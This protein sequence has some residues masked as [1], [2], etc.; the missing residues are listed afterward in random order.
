[1]MK[2]L[3]A[4]FVIF[5][6]IV[7][8]AGCDASKRAGG[9]ASAAIDT[10]TAN[11]GIDTVT[12]SK[13]S[14]VKIEPRGT[15]DF[16]KQAHRGGRGLMPENTIRAMINAINLDV[17]TLEM[18]AVITSDRKVILSHD[19]YFNSETT[20]PEDGS[21]I[22]KQ[23][24]DSFSIYKMTYEKTKTFDVGLK[25]YPAFPKQ[26]KVKA[27][28]PLLSDVI[29]SVEAYTAAKN[30]KPV[31]YNIE[32]KSRPSGDNKLHPAPEEYVELIMGVINQK[33]IRPRTIIQ[34][35]DFRTLQVMHKKYADVALAA[36][37]ENTRSLDDNI[38]D[39]GFTPTIYSP[40]FRLVTKELVEQ[41]HRLNM[42]IIPW[43]V[44]DK[45]KINSLKEWGVDGIISD[46]PDL[47][48]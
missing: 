35:F 25:P 45:E 2:N 1:M 13:S 30:K 22:T 6:V 10:V 21:I 41:C 28:K 44:N 7:C 38:K 43:T 23:N 17:T 5:H 42:K 47:F 37:I 48:N 8:S 36:L 20:T 39:L 19:Q 40:H 31:F 29:D 34:S 26:V 12:S 11:T 33:Q 4:G 27:I 15:S 9:P 16:D 18:D 14:S 46:Y 24:Q 32:T 3:L